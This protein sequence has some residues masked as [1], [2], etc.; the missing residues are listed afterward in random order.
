MMKSKKIEFGFILRLEKGEEIVSTLLK[1]LEDKKISSGYFTGIGAVSEV[2]L[3]HYSLKSKEYSKK[4]FKEPFEI[5]SLIGNI[6]VMNGKK[7]VH[8]HIAIS[9]KSMNVKAGHLT[10]ALVAATCE[11]NLIDLKTEIS[12]K[13]S[14]EI[15]LNLLDI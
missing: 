12:R 6:A 9:D 1:F 11:I 5:V 2:E 15:G 8:S 3:G 4:S 10:K 7:Y 14:K 13:F